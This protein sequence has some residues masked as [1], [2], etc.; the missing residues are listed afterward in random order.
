MKSTLCLILM[1]FMVPL[2][3]NA[4]SLSLSWQDNSNNE[5]G[6]AIERSEDGVNFTELARVSVNVQ[7]Y[8]DDTLTYGTTYWYR[9]RAYNAYG[10]SGYTNTVSGEPDENSEYPEAVKKLK[11]E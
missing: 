11:I 8:I 9:V 5:D 1:T 2:T 3:S 6:F 10:Y 7:E 4:A